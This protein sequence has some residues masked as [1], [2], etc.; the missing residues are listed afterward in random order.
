[1]TNKTLDLPLLRNKN[2]NLEAIK[3]E[4]NLLNPQTQHYLQAATS[5]NTRKA[6]QADVRHFMAWGGLLPTT[7]D[8]LIHYL[9]HQASLLNTR[10]LTRR[11]TALKHWHV[12][13]GFTDPT[14][15]PIVPKT[16][17][18]IKQVHGQPKA[19]ALPFTV[20]TLTTLVTYLQNQDRLIHWRNNALLQVGF[21]GA[22]RRS[23][24]AS[25]QTEQLRFVSEGLKILIPRSK[26]DQAGEGQTCAI[27][28]GNPQLCAVTAVKT[29]IEKSQLEKGALFR[30]L[31]KKG[32]LRKEALQ[33][34]HIN[35]LIQSLAHI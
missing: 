23:E 28:Y 13:Q 22:F 19:K 32:T 30:R 7:P 16:L 20:E 9:T 29:W 21:F 18:G 4:V 31:T 14:A 5:Q 34:G 2:D 26:T 11:L 1:M 3:Q 17:T 35:R 8:V 25:L 27:P 12:Y 15:H 33:A 10:T 6:Y 24:L